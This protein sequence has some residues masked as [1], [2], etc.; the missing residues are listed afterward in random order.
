MFSTARCSN[1]LRRKD[2]SEPQR[3]GEILP[4]VMED[5]SQRIIENRR[6][7]QQGKRTGGMKD[8]R[9]QQPELAFESK[10]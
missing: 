3:L 8:E 10:G 9:N 2:S 1:S 4:L 6:R 5:I 7:K